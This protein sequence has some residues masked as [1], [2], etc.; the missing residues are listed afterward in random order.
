MISRR[1]P[2]R[3]RD[4]SAHWALMVFSEIMFTSNSNR[5]TSKQHSPYIN[6]TT[7]ILLKIQTSFVGV[8]NLNK[9]IQICTTTRPLRFTLWVF[10]L[11]GIQISKGHGMVT[12]Q[13]RTNTILTSYKE[14]SQSS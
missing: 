6:S 2:V 14:Y 13:W 1:L 3:S 7:H 4:W 5:T 10:E 8:L 11:E 9:S 12:T